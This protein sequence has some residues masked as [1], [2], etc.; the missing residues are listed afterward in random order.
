MI[1]FVNSIDILS[2]FQSIKR[3]INGV[4]LSDRYNG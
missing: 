3:D 2:D 4:I 1:I